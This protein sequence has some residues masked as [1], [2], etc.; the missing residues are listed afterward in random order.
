MTEN[1]VHTTNIGSKTERLQ[2]RG[3]RSVDRNFVTLHEENRETIKMFFWHI[4][5]EIL[6]VRGSC[7]RDLNYLRTHIKFV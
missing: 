7:M 5:F 4:K 6:P 3:C 2:C 1:K